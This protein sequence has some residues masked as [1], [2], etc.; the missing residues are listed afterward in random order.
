M[1]KPQCIAFILAKYSSSQCRSQI[2]YMVWETSNQVLV[3]S[4][5]ANCRAAIKAF[6]I[7]FTILP[8]LTRLLSLSKFQGQVN[9]VVVLVQIPRASEQGS[10]WLIK[11]PTMLRL[12]AAHPRYLSVQFLNIFVLLAFTLVLSN[13][14]L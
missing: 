2:T 3:G 6:C 9:K 14:I 7:V 1:S 4:H 12:C 10:H 11:S 13:Y 8:D 5:C